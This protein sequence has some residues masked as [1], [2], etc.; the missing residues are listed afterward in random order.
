MLRSERDLVELHL[1]RRLLLGS[2]RSEPVHL[3]T[4]RLLVL[5]LGSVLQWLCVRQRHLH[6][7]AGHPGLLT[8]LGQSLVRADLDRRESPWATRPAGEAGTSCFHQGRVARSPTAAASGIGAL[9]SDAPQ[10]EKRFGR[11]VLMGTVQKATG[12]VLARARV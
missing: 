3:R 2:L 10:L 11:I 1:G 6:L 12:K 8:L 7:P 9:K 4:P 5:G